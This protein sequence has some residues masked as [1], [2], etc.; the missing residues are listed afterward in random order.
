MSKFRGRPSRQKHSSLLGR[1]GPLVAVVGVSTDPQKYGHRIFTDLIDSGYSVVGINPRG[2]VV[3]GQT[4]W[5][6]LQAVPDKPDLDDGR[7]ATG[8]APDCRSVPAVGN[9]YHLMQPGLSRTRLQP[10]NKRLECC[11]RL[12]HETRKPL[13]DQ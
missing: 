12:F 7:P 8:H 2:G 6:S 5:P 10:P 1:G 13:V 3:A 11:T 9:Y 4:L